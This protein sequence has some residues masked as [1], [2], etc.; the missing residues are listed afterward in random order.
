MRIVTTTLAALC[1]ATCLTAGD[2]AAK[3]LPA[4]FYSKNAK[5]ATSPD[6]YAWKSESF[7]KAGGTA[8]DGKLKWEANEHAGAFSTALKN[9][10]QDVNQTGATQTLTVA[11]V[12]M[13]TQMLGGVHDF[14]VEAAIRDAKGDV[15]ACLYWTYHKYEQDREAGDRQAADSFFAALKKDLLN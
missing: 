5:K 15:V 7:N 8:W 11:V 3:T 1:L 12:S 10:L 4:E 13:K 9:V 6:T 2:S 14:I